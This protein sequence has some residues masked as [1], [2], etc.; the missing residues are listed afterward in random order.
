MTPPSAFRRTRERPRRQSTQQLS[1]FQ[2]AGVAQAAASFG[3]VGG[4]D[5]LASVRGGLGLDRLSVSAGSGSGG[6][7]VEAG[8]Y[9]ANGVMSAPNKAAPAVLR[10]K[11]KST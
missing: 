7:T 9:V 11:S 10:R 4:S 6:A 8:K 3:G 2:L 5:P 1:P